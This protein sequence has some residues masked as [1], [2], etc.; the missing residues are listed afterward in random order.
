MMILRI[1]HSKPM[2]TFLKPVSRRLIPAFLLLP[3]A[4][5]GQSIEKHTFSQA[6]AS[7]YYLAI[8]P[9]GPVKGVLV[10]FTTFPN[11]ESILPETRLHNV[12]S[13]NQILTIYASVAPSLAADSV[14]VKKINTI[15]KDV[16]V[17]FSADTSK[18][19]LAGFS[20][21]GNIVLRYTE[22]VYANPGQFPLQ[23]KAVFG[24]ASFVDLPGVW[25]WSERELK[26][27]YYPGN[28]GDA[29][30]I[31]NTLN[32]D[33]APT[34]T[35]LNQLKQ[36]TPFD[37]EADGP[38][39]ERFLTGVPVRL[40]YDTDISWQLKTRHNSVYDTEMAD[41]SE[42]ISRLL[43]AGNQDAEFISA[44]QP[45]YRSNGIRNPNSLSIVDETECIQ[46]LINKM[47]ILNPVRPL[48][49]KA[50]YVFPIPESWSIERTAFPPLYSPNVPYKGFEEIHFPPGWGNSK[51]EDYWTVSYLFRLNGKQNMDVS[52]L[53]DFIKVYYEGLIAD[54]VPRRNIP[55]EKLVPISAVLKK[56]KT[57]QGDLETYSGV[58]SSLDYLAQIPIKL[59]CRIHLKP[60]G[61]NFT[62]VLIE[63][64][65]KPYEHPIWKKMESTVQLFQCGTKKAE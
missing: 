4:V 29:K 34:E 8:R 39:N 20:F 52:A 51:T 45:G 46:W 38:G 44:T 3:F 54:N 5:A 60:G 42:L 37:R 62:P 21:A 1:T 24:I 59:N 15:L 48:A 65:P 43:Q 16:T 49:W 30:F 26:K 33:N 17:N 13:N 27:N 28:T 40:Y 14:A 47:N 31:L 9:Q 23:P 57:E 25:H 19:A 22:Q 50:P 7:D 64:S 2:K 32:K 41:G 12:A 36:L 35:A 10:L 63:V 56:V 6:N 53:Q 61:E 11:P 18:F 58:V 55:K